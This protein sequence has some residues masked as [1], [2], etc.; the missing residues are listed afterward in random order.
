M[1]RGVV[2]GVMF[3]TV[4]KLPM[5]L[6]YLISVQ[7][8]RDRASLVEIIM[9]NQRGCIRRRRQKNLRNEKEEGKSCQVPRTI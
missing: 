6:N 1:P 8:G 3:E 5:V 7:S 9:Y 2:R 4:L